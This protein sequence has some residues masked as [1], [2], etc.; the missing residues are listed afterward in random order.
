MQTARTRHND[1]Q[2]DPER[3]RL[4]YLFLDRLCRLRELEEA[5]EPTR[6][7]A[8]RRLL[9]HALYSTY[10]DCV[11]IGLRTLARAMLGLPQDA[12]GVDE[13]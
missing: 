9:G 7:A 8:E 5:W 6:T 2:A 11:R 12:I 4:A 3:H 1:I 10:E 13:S